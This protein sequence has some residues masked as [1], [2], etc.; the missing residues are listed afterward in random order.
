MEKFYSYGP[1]C[2]FVSGMGKE[3]EEHRQSL[4]VI[5]WS[6]GVDGKCRKVLE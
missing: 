2:R 1:S 3:M 5:A 4:N 6:N